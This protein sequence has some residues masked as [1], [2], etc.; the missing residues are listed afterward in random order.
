M[1]RCGG[2]DSPVSVGIYDLVPV[3]SYTVSLVVASDSCQCKSYRSNILEPHGAPPPSPHPH[4][5]EKVVNRR[6]S[7]DTLRGTVAWDGLFAHSIMFDEGILD[8]KFFWFWPEIRRD[9]LNF[10]S[11]GVFSIYGKILLAHSSYT[12]KYSWRILQIRLYSLSV[13]S[14][15][16]KILLAT[17][18]STWTLNKAWWF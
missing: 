8:Q 4:P 13:L 18:Y 2:S 11:I 6:K 16:A 5:K 9:K 1:S 12:A 10:M 17:L 15:H 3:I 14:M 7:N